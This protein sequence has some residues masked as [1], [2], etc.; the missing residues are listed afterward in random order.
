MIRFSKVWFALVTLSTGAIGYWSCS[1]G[2]QQGGEALARTH[3]GGCHLF[4]E[5]SLLPKKV[6]DEG[7]LPHMAA[8]LGI[9]YR[10]LNL[11]SL[12][13]ANEQVVVDAG[14]F[15]VEPVVSQKEWESIV[16]YYLQNA[17]EKLPDTVRKEAPQ[18][19]T[20]FQ[21][22]TTPHPI[23]AMVTAVRY[24]SLNQRIWAGLRSGAIYVLDP[25]LRPVDSLF[26]SRSPFSDIRFRKN[27]WDLLGMGIMDPNDKSTGDLFRLSKEEGRWK[28]KALVEGLRRPVHMSQADINKDGREDVVVS[29]YGNYVGRLAWYEAMANDSMRMHIIED[30]P[31]ARQTYWHDYNGDGRKDLWVLWAQGDEQIAVYLNDDRGNFVKKVLLRFSPVFGSG[32]FELADFNKDGHMDILY[33]NGD[34]ADHSHTMKPYHG[35]RIYLNNGSGVFKESFFYPMHGATQAQA[36]DFDG[37]GDLDIAAIAFF[38]NYARQPVESF[39]YLENQGGGK[40]QPRTFGDTNLGRWLTMDIADVDRDGDQDILLGSFSLTITPTPKEV[41][42]RWNRE[43]KGVVLLEN[44][45]R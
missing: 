25:N 42:E 11:D 43:N 22:R 2:G 44:K 34:N 17:P 8:R 28:G 7:V 30:R 45:L 32:Y 14:I 15:P 10:G 29:E 27:E 19:L 26:R 4:P 35:I 3:C 6:W 9:S 38:P 1:T 40:Y 24:D 36:R 23:Q 39:V 5:P 33:S 16:A 37:D 21:V 12:H 41:K 20:G 13:N 31:G 18:L